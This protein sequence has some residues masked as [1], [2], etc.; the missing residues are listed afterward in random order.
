[1]AINR[2]MKPLQRDFSTEHYIPNFDAWA[3]GLQQKE[4]DHN[5]VLAE[6]DKLSS[7]VPKG[8]YATQDA[9]NNLLTE[10]KNQSAA[11]SQ[12]LNDP[13]KSS[14]NE[15]R[16]RIQQLATETTSNPWMR[17]LEMDEQLMPVAAKLGTSQTLATDIQTAVD[18][19]T[20]QYV[21]AKN[22]E[23]INPTW[24]GN[25]ETKDTYSMFRNVVKQIPDKFIDIE[26]MGFDDLE[27]V[28]VK[29]DDGTT[30]TSYF[31]KGQHVQRVFK[32]IHQLKNFLDPTGVYGDHAKFVYESL[33][34]DDRAYYDA[35]YKHLSPEEKEKKF[36]EDLYNAA[37]ID[38]HDKTIIRE[39]VK[40]VRG[41]KA[42][43]E[44]GSETPIVPHKV[45][46]YEDT[47]PVILD[48]I[49][50]VGEIIS[51]VATERKNIDKIGTAEGKGVSTNNIDVKKLNYSIKEEISK[52][53]D[54]VKPGEVDH[55]L[56][57]IFIKDDNGKF[58]IN[59][60]WKENEKIKQIIL[61]P[62]SYQGK[63][64]EDQ[65]HE[66]NNEIISRQNQLSVR[67]DI[68][69]DHLGLGREQ[70]HVI[71]EVYANAKKRAEKR[72]WH[73]V[74]P[75][76]MIK[77]QE[78]R[79]ENKAKY[80]EHVTSKIEDIQNNIV[81]KEFDTVLPNNPL[82]KDKIKKAN[83]YLRKTS[84][85]VNQ[86]KTNYY[87]VYGDT[88]D[89]IRSVQMIN[90]AMRSAITVNQN[91]MK[92]GDVLIT[93][94]KEREA[95]ANA[96]N[97]FFENPG[98]GTDNYFKE[99]QQD[100]GIFFDKEE[101]TYNMRVNLRNQDL[102]DKLGIE[103][104][105]AFIEVPF[106]KNAKIGDKTMEEYLGIEGSPELVSRMHQI[107]R[108]FANNKNY[109]SESRD[110]DHS[111]TISLDVYDPNRDKGVIEARMDIRLGNNTKHVIRVP[112]T[113]VAAEIDLFIK[114]IKNV[115]YSE[116]ILENASK[117]IIAKSGG[118]VPEEKAKD[119]V[120][121][122]I[123]SNIIDLS[124]LDN[125]YF[126]VKEGESAMLNRHSVEFL[127]K[128]GRDIYGSKTPAKMEITSAYRDSE[129]NELVGG[130][131]NSP[132]KYGMA[133]DLSVKG[134]SG[135]NVVKAVEQILGKKIEKNKFYTLPSKY[136]LRVM[137]HFGTEDHLHF[138]IIN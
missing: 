31:L 137:R 70:E 24:Y 96:L 20:G 47:Q 72:F 86:V 40:E 79:T 99:Y 121:Q 126:S 78:M 84:K 134:E 61:K 27:V 67:E 35:K 32:D 46:S 93:D 39:N 19:K 88:P 127:T 73:G 112:S 2:F 44:E 66:M 58:S 98:K 50:N 34:G 54:Y 62:T 135:Q 80:D 1:M 83:E 33:S 124:E 123:G 128:L 74:S 42:G 89:G 41:S 101:G 111:T 129:T 100:I 30:S 51:T 6:L 25:V 68:L 8:G 114:D 85:E 113:R 82:A 7:L 22:P 136:G 53:L 130:S 4:L 92:I 125:P 63:T 14:I 87:H 107:E 103:K 15:A 12:D 65:I 5:N 71:Q 43:K 116:D 52:G 45:M 23:D 3:K 132:H 9:R 131:E 29:N 81:E 69:Y 37:L 13:T 117:V 28:N 21:Q 48:R 77:L 109:I 105:P 106:P 64:I 59:P 26:S 57:D 95:I 138:E 49:G 110:G 108:D 97:N 133:F 10:V 16:R 90:E 38:I 122:A 102:A 18:P 91:N 56:A 119:I 118:T 75:V 94:P 17:A 11:I 76:E 36:Y 60:I 115:P 55:T 104:G 120:R